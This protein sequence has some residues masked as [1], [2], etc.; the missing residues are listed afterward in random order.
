MYMNVFKFEPIYQE[1]VWGGQMIRKEFNR[2]ISSNSMVGESWEIVDREDNQSVVKSGKFKGKT[3]RFLIQRHTNEIMGP[4]WKPENQFPILVKWLDCKERLS[5]QVH[6]PESIAK[7]LGGEPKTENW[8]VVKADDNAGLFLGLKKEITEKQFR[9]AILSGNVESLCQRIKS[10]NRD[11][12]LVESGT[13][14]AIDAG[15]L[16]LEIQQNSDTTYRAY[17]WNRVGIDGKKRLLHLEE[18]IK[19]IDFG[20]TIPRKVDGKYDYG[21]NILA[22]CDKFRITQFIS[23][24]DNVIRIKNKNQECIIIHLIDGSVKV[25]DQILKSGDQA[26]SP[27]DSSCTLKAI[28]DSTFLITDKFS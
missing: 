11:S 8:F 3:I 23:K 18:S 26:L 28:V 19:C 20:S 25:G 14:H 5:L 9:K 13:L 22:D 15:N 24:K 10:K 17:D 7:K 12:V 21:A 2:E 27:Y 6:P 16:I 4:N 1:R